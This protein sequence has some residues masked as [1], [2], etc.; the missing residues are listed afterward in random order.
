MAL[1]GKPKRQP[2]KATDNFNA[3][4][5]KYALQGKWLTL[6]LSSFKTQFTTRDDDDRWIVNPVAHGVVHSEFGTDDIL[7]ASLTLV[8]DPSPRENP[9]FGRVFFQRMGPSGNYPAFCVAEAFVNDPRGKIAAH[10][11]A[12]FDSAAISDAQFLH[13]TF[14]REEQDVDAI[15]ADLIENQHGG[16]HDLLDIQI[17]RQAV[18]PKSPPESWLWGRDW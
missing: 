9:R 4:S 10:L 17:T 5:V 11:H 16:D 15:V 18:L 12:A 13:V 2:L 1:F 6:A 3:R 14:R 8:Q 7:R